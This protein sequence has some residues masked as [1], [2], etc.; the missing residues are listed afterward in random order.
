MPWIRLLA[1]T[2]ALALAIALCAWWSIVFTRGALG[3]SSLWV[4]S[5]V[6]CGV[7]LTSPRKQWLPYML[8]AFVASIMVNFLC[9][10]VD[11]RGVVLSFANTLDAWIVAALVARHAGDPS[12]LANIKRS[13]SVAAFSTLLACSVSGLIAA[14]VDHAYATAPAPF[15][16]LFC[17][18]LASHVLGMAIFATLTIAA[19][20]EGKRMLGKPGR[21]LELAATLVLIAVVCWMVFAQPLFSITFIIF[22]PLLLCVFRH[23]FSGFVPATAIIAVI[24]TSL[25]AAGHGPFL[26][27][28]I[29]DVQSTLMLQ[30]FIASVCLFAFPMAAV[31]TERQLLVRRLVE[32]ERDYRIL[33]EHSHDLI[34]RIG[35][36][37]LR[38]YTSPSATQLLGWPHAEFGKPRWD[39]VHPGDVDNYKQTL[40]D[41]FADG[42]TRMFTV[43]LLHAD[44]H[45]VWM[46]LGI[47][48]VPGMRAGD[49]PEVIYSGRDV[50][51]REHARQLLAQLARHDTL[52]GLGNRMYFDERLELA[53]ARSHRNARK[54][55]VLY[56]DI[57]RFKQINDTHGHA[58]GDAILVEF[59]AR[60]RLCVR[61][62]DF[63]ARLGGD[64][65]VVLVEDIDAPNAPGTIAE[66]LIAS[67]QEEIVAGDVHVRATASI[68]IAESAATD[69]DADALLRRADAALY[70]AKSAGRN[71]W[72]T[73]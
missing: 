51:E 22:P 44:G 55:A 6:L 73:A 15:L 58:V 56:I 54:L 33:A 35:V 13:I 23:R 49:L 61:A 71:T 28:R 47:S 69:R 21:R 68:G 17:T 12:R 60:L 14:L 34:V 40:K 11:P 5:G 2:F 52:T 20:A 67:L 3:L 42:E 31:L 4:A 41:V 16:L 38:R 10:G 9:K 63:P 8:A 27:P 70:A 39:L 59:A 19:R 1:R 37:G 57:D 48:R 36:D 50:T 25:T 46:E 53:L 43:R 24:A 66:K 64:E 29:I 72:R 45:Y 30:G 65:F 32:S 26:D 7:L 18:W 62:T